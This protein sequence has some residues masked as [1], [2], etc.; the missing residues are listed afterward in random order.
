MY[1]RYRYV[2]YGL[3][4]L[5]REKYS[6]THD[7]THIVSVTLTHSLSPQTQYHSAIYHTVCNYNSPTYPG[8]SVLYSRGLQHISATTRN[9]AGDAA[10]GHGTIMHGT[11]PLP[12]GSRCKP[13]SPEG[14]PAGGH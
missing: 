8:Y 6:C 2:L 11:P 1:A 12:P 4:D 5:L 13:L 3:Y 9:R 10:D 7:C 14:T